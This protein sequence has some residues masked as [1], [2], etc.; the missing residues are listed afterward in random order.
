VNATNS[1]SSVPIGTALSSGRKWATPNGFGKASEVPPGAGSCTSRGRR[2]RPTAVRP[3]SRKPAAATGRQRRDGSFPV[4]KKKTMNARRNVTP[5]KLTWVN[6]PT[7]SAAGSAPGK[8]ATP[9]TAYMEA[10][11]T[12]ASP[13]LSLSISQPIK[14]PAWRTMSVPSVA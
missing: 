8:V 6:A 1:P 4:G 12:M 13:A 10:R 11:P 3:A 7:C 5:V 14:C 2:T 9:S